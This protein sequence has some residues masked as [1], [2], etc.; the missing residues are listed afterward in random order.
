M[1]KDEKLVEEKENFF[2]KMKE[3]KKYNL[4]KCK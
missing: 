1:K 2:K 4:L 3:D